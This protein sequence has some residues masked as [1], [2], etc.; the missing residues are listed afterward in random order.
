MEKSLIVILV[1]PA[2]EVLLSRPTI[3]FSQP[4]VIIIIYTLRYTY[5][6]YQRSNLVILVLKAIVEETKFLSNPVDLSNVPDNSF[7]FQLIIFEKI[8]S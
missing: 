6:L 3:D 2:C 7:K 5:P 4:V 1:H 8:T